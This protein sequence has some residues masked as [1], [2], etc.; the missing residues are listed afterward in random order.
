MKLLLC[1][2]VDP[3]GIVGDVVEVSAGYGR[4][5]LIP[6]NLATEPTEANVRK[7]AEA[8]RI[9]ER[10]RA[11][12]RTQLQRLAEALEGVE[13]TVRAKSNEE[14]HLYGSVGR[15]EIAVALEEE[16][17]FIN[18]DHI[19]LDAPIRHLDT[20]TVDIR[21]ADD[22]TSSIKVW[23]VRDKVEGEDDSADDET[24]PFAGSTSSGKEADNDD[25][26]ADR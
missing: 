17:H 20:V 12:Q 6:H 25:G 24:E 2:N 26:R 9:A 7:L 18:P 21:F 14:G 19:Q 1:Q 3:L 5:Y 22:L 15:R 11:E 23:V 13:V 4:N 8:R 10:V 16:G